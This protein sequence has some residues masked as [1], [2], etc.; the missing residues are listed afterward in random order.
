MST[1][2]WVL[3]GLVVLLAIVVI[4]IYNGLVSGRQEVRKSGQAAP[5]SSFKDIFGIFGL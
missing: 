1:G 4:G 2:L 3:I 5:W